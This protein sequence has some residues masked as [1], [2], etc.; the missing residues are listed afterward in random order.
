VS[1]SRQRFLRLPDGRQVD[2]GAGY[3]FTVIEAG[4]RFEGERLYD[5]SVGV[6]TPASSYRV[7][8]GSLEAAR[9]LAARLTAEAEAI[10]DDRSGPKG[11][12]D[13]T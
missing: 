6:F 13:A 1:E 12:A 5:D 10:M 2:I 9:E 8:C 3:S 11:A 4:V 7:P